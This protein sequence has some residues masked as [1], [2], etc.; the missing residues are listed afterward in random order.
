MTAILHGVRGCLQQRW[1]WVLMP[2]LDNSKQRD[3]G[4][5]TILRHKVAA[6]FPT[7]RPCTDA[8]KAKP[9]PMS[10]S[11]FAG[12]KIAPPPSR[13]IIFYWIKWERSV[14]KMCA[15]CLVACCT[16]P[17]SF[18]MPVLMHKIFIGL[19]SYCVKVQEFVVEMLLGK[20]C[21][22]RYSKTIHEILWRYQL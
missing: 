14:Y 2:R 15:D 1:L 17:N 11:R 21:G 12:I 6:L 18:L 8:G 13:W 7:K 3:D 4:R 10:W 5:L 9:L 22:N 20:H 19:P 16:M